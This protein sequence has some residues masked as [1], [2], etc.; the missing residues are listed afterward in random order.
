MKFLL[1]KGADVNAPLRKGDTPLMKAVDGND[2]ALLNLLLEHGADVNAK[3]RKG[4][5]PLSRAEEIGNKEILEA[6]KNAPAKE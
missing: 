3:G 1:E 4:R 2:L 6:L 5:T